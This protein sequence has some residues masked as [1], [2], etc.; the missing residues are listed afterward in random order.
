VFGGSG[1]CGRRFFGQVA[2]TLI[3]L[4]LTLALAKK[5]KN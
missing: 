4:I 2:S 5:Y 3:I 1:C